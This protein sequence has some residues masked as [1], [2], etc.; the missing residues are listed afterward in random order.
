MRGVLLV[1]FTSIFLKS[2]FTVQYMMLVAVLLLCCC[3]WTPRRDA[4]VFSFFSSWEPGPLLCSF[5][6]LSGAGDDLVIPGQLQ[7]VN[8]KWLRENQK[9][10]ESQETLRKTFLLKFSHKVAWIR[11]GSI[12]CG[13]VGKKS[14]CN[15]GV[16][17][18]SGSI[19]GSGRSPGGGN[20][21]PLQ[22]SCL[23]NPMDRGAWKVSVHRVTKSLTFLGFKGNYFPSDI[24][25][26]KLEA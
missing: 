2:W 18:D 14:T 13:S 5:Q 7:G 25:A 26:I 9:K 11:K 17:G 8:P 23:G 20:G 10:V 6:E 16:A 21:N 4:F 1:I 15:A 19:P 24:W 22:Y 12:P 3:F